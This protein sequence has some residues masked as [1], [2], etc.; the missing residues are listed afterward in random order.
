MKFT[1]ILFAL[2]T[3]HA[4]G[5]D[6]IEGTYDSEKRIFT[7]ANG[8]R[9]ISNFRYGVAPYED[10]HS[11]L[12]GV[13]DTTGRIILKP[14]YYEIEGFGGGVSRV[15]KKEEP[16]E[17]TYGFIDTLGNEILPPIYDDADEWWSRSMRFAEV[18]VVGK[19]G[20]Y[21]IFDYSGKKLTPLKYQSIWEFHGGLVRVYNEGKWGFVNKEGKEIIALQYTEAHDFSG[22]RALVKKNGKYGWID[23]EGKTV[24]PF[25][26]EWAQNFYGKWA[27]V[28]KD[29][30]MI[31]IDYEGNP[32]LPDVYDGVGYYSEGVAWAR[33][34]D[35]WGFID[36]AGMVVIPLQYKKVGNFQKGRAWVWRED[37]K[38]GHIDHDGNVTT[39]II[40]DQVNDFSSQYTGDSL[41]SSAKL[42][43]KYGKLGINGNLAIP[44]EYI[45]ID[46]FSHGLAKVKKET[47]EGNK[48][49]YVDY[50]GKEV[51]P[52]IYDKAETFSKTNGVAIVEKDGKRGI[53][54]TKGEFILE[55]K[56]QSIYD[57][58][59][60]TYEVRDPNG[61]YVIDANGKKI[62]Q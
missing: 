49:G 3:I 29:G 33:K 39:P 62:E 42:N 41:F 21:G 28:K 13:I 54:N 14:T 30:K 40:Y 11:N 18:L 35:K 44:C 17:L 24:I 19:D 6:R 31:F 25:E 7:L 22:D 55:L 15:T 8:S 56:Q 50:S 51:V 9:S 45:G 37:G 2:I 60:G 52:C 36:S 61:K 48:F 12:T 32:K 53:I 23:R 46:H 57:K 4:F 26:Y 59:D 34:D 10:Y 16:W 47:P 27:K 58:R 20:K 43:N 38:W 1:L 5:Q